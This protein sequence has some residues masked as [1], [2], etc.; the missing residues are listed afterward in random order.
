M[1]PNIPPPSAGSIDTKKQPPGKVIY[2]EDLVFK[3]GTHGW[4][5]NNLIY[6]PGQRAIQ[7]NLI[8]AEWA[9]H[10][11]QTGQLAV[12]G[13][14]MRA[15][16][17]TPAD[18]ALLMIGGSADLKLHA[19]DNLAVDRIGRPLPATGRY[20]TAAAQIVDMPAPTPAFGVSVL[21]CVT[22]DR[23]KGWGE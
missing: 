9:G 4:V 14:V 23:L 5:V 7:Y 22:C 17:D 16:P 11:Y 3:G 20:T 12:V 2:G 6:N 19:S 8:A 1:D 18:V 10:A 15:G 21:P 13:N